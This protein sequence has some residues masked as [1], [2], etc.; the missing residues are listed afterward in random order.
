MMMIR[1]ARASGDRYVLPFPLYLFF[2]F[3]KYT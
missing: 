2:P 3:S 1:S